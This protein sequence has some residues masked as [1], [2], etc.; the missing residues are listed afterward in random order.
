LTLYMPL[1]LMLNGKISWGHVFTGYLGLL[2][3]GGA[4]LA[5]SLLCSALSPNQLVAA[6]LAAAAVTLFVLLWLLSRIA[7]PPLDQIIA[8]LS[9]HD[10][11]FRPFM[12]GILSTQ[13][14]VFYISL[15]V[16][17]LTI[18]TRVIEARRWRS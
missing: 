10:K 3:I 1:L 11:H 14:V 5:I 8:Y 7:S 16:V 15:M 12:R 17:A 13:D 18:S 9:I 2:L 6:I 4:S